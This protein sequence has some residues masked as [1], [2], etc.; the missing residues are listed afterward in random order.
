[1][2][3]N[4][5]DNTENQLTLAFDTSGRAGSA[6]VGFD[7]KIAVSRSFSSKLKHSS[8]LFTTIISLLDEIGKKPSDIRRVFFTKGPGSFTGLRIG[9]TLAKMMHLANNKIKI[10]GLNTLDCLAKNL[11]NSEFDRIGSI[12]DAKRGL[13]FNAV[14][15]KNDGKLKKI[16]D[17]SVEKADQFLIKSADKPIC[18][19]GEGLVFYRDRFENANVTIADEDLWTVKA[20]NVYA[21]GQEMAEN[22]NF[23]QA[24]SLAPDYMRKPDAKVKSR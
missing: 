12:I 18:L 16:I 9:V 8:E 20:E 6:A 10:V 19:L 24:I 17:D 11:E 5:N 3:E 22:G 15:E 4:R 23:S 1:M 21:L 13:F 14:Y 2:S 7:R